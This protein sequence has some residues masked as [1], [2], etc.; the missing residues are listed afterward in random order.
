[1][2]ADYDVCIIGSGAGGGP[3]AY[4]LAKAG[5]DVVVLGHFH[6]EHRLEAVPPSPPGRVFVLPEW[7][8]S[9]RHLRVT[10]DGDVAIVDSSI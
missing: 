2:T 1:M 9:R 3:V 7:K 4:T 5:H 8:T 6:E 10:A